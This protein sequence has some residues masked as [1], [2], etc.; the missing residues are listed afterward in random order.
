VQRVSNW[1]KVGQ[2]FRVS[3]ELAIAYLGGVY[4]GEA[5]GRYRVEDRIEPRAL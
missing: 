2:A 3:L 5:R 4:I 1:D